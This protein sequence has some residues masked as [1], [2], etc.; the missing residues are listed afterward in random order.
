LIKDEA[1]LMAACR[2]VLLNPVRRTGTDPRHW[3]W[4]SM[5]STVGLDHPPACLDVGWILS[6][7]GNTPAKARVAFNEFVDAGRE[8]TSVPG[9][10]V[11]ARSE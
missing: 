5:R 6:H 7:F 3:R 11:R 8:L 9:T 1:Y 10:E 2:Y 4:S